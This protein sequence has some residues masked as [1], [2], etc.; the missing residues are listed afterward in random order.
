MDNRRGPADRLKGPYSGTYV[1]GGR[2][3]DRPGVKY[4]SVIR[5]KYPAG[6]RNVS[7][8]ILVIDHDQSKV[9]RIQ[10]PLA[11][12][13][14]EVI[15]ATGAAEGMQ[16]IEKQQP[17][18]A[19]IEAL[20]PDKN[21]P[22]LCQEIKDSPLGK[23]MPVIIML[24][25]DDEAKAEAQAMDLHGCDML[26]DRSIQDQELLDLLQRLFEEQ[27]VEAEP[28]EEPVEEPAAATAAPEPVE[29]PAKSDMLL[30]TY[31]LDG[32]LQKLDSI[33]EEQP[34]PEAA[35]GQQAAE[36]AGD[37]SHIA[38]ELGGRRTEQPAPEQ[39]TDSGED[40]DSQLDSVLSM[41]EASPPAPVQTASPVALYEE[42]EAKT[43]TQ[44]ETPATP[45]VQAEAA[46]PE[47]FPEGEPSAELPLDEIV[48]ETL[49]TEESVAEPAVYPARSVPFPAPMPEAEAARGGFKKYWWVAAAVFAIALV[50]AGIMLMPD[51]SQSEPVV[52]NLTGDA[53]TPAGEGEPATAALISIPASTPTVEAEEEPVAE[54]PAAE[55]APKQEPVKVAKAVEPVAKPKPR[56][57]TPKPAPKRVTPKPE[58]VIAKPTPK[59]EPVKAAPV[60]VKQEPKPEPVKAEPVVA[61]PEPKPE[62]A[63][64]PVKIAPAPVQVEQPPAE[65]IFEPPVV[66]ERID[67]VYPKKALRRAAGGTI[68][69]KL[70]ISESGRIVRVTVDQGAPVPE[71]EAAAVNAVLR[72]RYRPATEDGVAV[73]AWTTAEFSF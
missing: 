39:E 64:A 73:K 13:G 36:Q 51:G 18:L 65:P 42:V 38:E 26:I 6:D 55:P 2:P 62:P 57:V 7:Y 67:P 27:Q 33:I 37:F 1:L 68:I 23:S 8:K 29:P 31:E 63:L 24:E 59:P 35:E 61:T 45:E 9:E 56:T 54:P 34:K 43:A 32:A 25:T 44:K 41:G 30:D 69:L 40:I 4:R 28:A 11:E 20:L 12:A 22:Q 16:T 3:P 52:A 15:V 17:D 10:R 70:L 5:S 21:G 72:W 47:L 49:A 14:Y 58:P 46:E 48:S 19:V 50:G 66:L 71:L 60:V 53:G